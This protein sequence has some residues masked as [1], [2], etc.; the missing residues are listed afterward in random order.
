[1]LLSVLLLASVDGGRGHDSR[2]LAEATVDIVTAQ[3]TLDEQIFA[4]GGVTFDTDDFKLKL[5]FY[6]F[7]P[8]KEEGPP[9]VMTNRLHPDNITA[10]VL[11]TSPLVVN[12]TIREVCTS[13]QPCTNPGDLSAYEVATDLDF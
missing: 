5:V 4:D 2:A 7:N 12:V 9:V 3:F 11:S 6:S 13:G 8:I 10:E 1:M